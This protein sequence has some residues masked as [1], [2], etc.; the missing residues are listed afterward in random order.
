MDR[1]NFCTKHCSCIGEF[2]GNFFPGCRC[3]RKC[4]T[5]QCPCFAAAREC[6]V[7]LCRGCDPN[8][9]PAEDAC[10]NQTLRYRLHKRLL[11]GLS[12]VP[13]AGWGVFSDHQWIKRDEFIHEYGGEIISQEEAERRGDLYDKLNR[14]YLFNLNT[15][16]VVD[17]A[18]NGNKTKFANHSKK[19]NCYTRVVNVG[20]EHMIGI[21]ALHDI[22]PHTELFFDYR[23][24]QELVHE[25]F[26]K[27]AMVVD[28]MKDPFMAGKVTNTHN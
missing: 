17:A 12:E 4:R 10:H 13:G 23:Y 14:S 7:D 25:D 24:D 27:D 16:Y 15:E 18:R 1:N 3:S 20:S 19:P 22:P 28:W 2:C 9:D 8:S 21:Y 26:I 5:K 6:D 11:L